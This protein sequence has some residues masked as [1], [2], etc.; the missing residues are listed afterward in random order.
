MKLIYS[1]RQLRKYL[2]YGVIIISALYLLLRLQQPN[3]LLQPVNQDAPFLSPQVRNAIA[4]SF[5]SNRLRS[6]ISSGPASSLTRRSR[7]PSTIFNVKKRFVRLPSHSNPGLDHFPVHTP[8][9]SLF[10]KS[11][12]ILDF[13]IKSAVSQF[14]PDLASNW[15]WRPFSRQSSHLNSSDRQ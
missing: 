7:S 3:C 1:N 11:P 9:L 2:L 10:S 14:N 8:H 13:Q 12:S 6:A 15:L 5:M 4:S